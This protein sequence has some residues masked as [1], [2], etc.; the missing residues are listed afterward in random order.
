MY[1]LRNDPGR[2]NH[3]TP[4]PRALD[5]R[6]RPN[7][8]RAQRRQARYRREPQRSRTPARART[9][10]RPVTVDLE[11]LGRQSER[12]LEQLRD[13]R[14]ELA[15]IKTRLTALGSAFGLLITHIASLNNR[16]DHIEVKQ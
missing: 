11:F 1:G 14:S 4:A 8:R 13:V 3:R 10:A 9:G 7:P 6:P 12:I 2:R 16:I 5:A 15:N